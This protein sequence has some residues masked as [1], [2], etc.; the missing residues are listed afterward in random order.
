MGEGS[1]FEA[2]LAPPTSTIKLRL[3]LSSACFEFLSVSAIL[4][5]YLSFT[6]SKKGIHVLYALY[7]L[8]KPP[9]SQDKEG[10]KIK[11]SL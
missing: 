11:T 4:D 9:K 3:L 2:L 7:R 8:A 10:R 1:A 5:L 6:V